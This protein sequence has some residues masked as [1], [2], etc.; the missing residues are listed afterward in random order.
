MAFVMDMPAS[1]IVANNVHA[2]AKVLNNR[3]HSNICSLGKR[4]CFWISVNLQKCTYTY[5]SLQF[6]AE[7]NTSDRTFISFHTNYDSKLIHFDI[8]IT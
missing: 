6:S 1:L 8:C 5:N 3:H 2:A 7:I 4:A